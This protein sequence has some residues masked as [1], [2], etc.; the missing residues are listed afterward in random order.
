[1]NRNDCQN[2]GYVL[3]GYPKNAQNAQDV[4]VI[5]PT[6]PEKKVL[7]DGEEEEEEAPVDDEEEMDL[8]P[9]LQKN[10]YPESVI[11]LNASEL[12]LKRRSNAL[13]AGGQAGAEKWHTSKLGQKL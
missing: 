3:D 11:C 10:I 8:K 5:T 9:V 1:M 12:F 2:R 7:A 13:H 4:F 6:K